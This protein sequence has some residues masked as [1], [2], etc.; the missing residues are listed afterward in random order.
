MTVQRNLRLIAQRRNANMVNG[1]FGARVRN[2]AVLVCKLVSAE[3]RNTTTTTD[4]HVT[5]LP[6]CSRATLSPAIMVRLNA[7]MVNGENGNSALNPVV[8]AI[9]L[10][11]VM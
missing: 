9:K 10:E 3:Q 8:K 6:T 2:H 7:S 4:T 1:W 11:L 5:K